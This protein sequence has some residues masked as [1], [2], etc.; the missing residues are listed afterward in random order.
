MKSLNYLFTVSELRFLQYHVCTINVLINKRV[1]NHVTYSTSI[2][3]SF[4][5][6][7]SHV[8]NQGAY[9]YLRNTSGRWGRHWFKIQHGFTKDCLYLSSL[10]LPFINRSFM[11]TRNTKV[12]KILIWG[13]IVLNSKLMKK[14]RRTLI[15][16]NSLIIIF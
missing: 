15:I 8:D 9:V 1:C 14:S 16:E 4:Q 11:G 2:G 6:C 5:P 10:V 3:N 13:K 7:A 12:Q